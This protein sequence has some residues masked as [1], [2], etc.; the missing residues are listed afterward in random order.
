MFWNAQYSFWQDV[1][2]SNTVFWSWDC[3]YWRSWDSKPPLLSFC[4]GGETATSTAPL[5]LNVFRYWKNT[6]PGRK[7]LISTLAI[8]ETSSRVEKHSSP[9]TCWDLDFYSLRFPDISREGEEKLLQSS[10]IKQQKLRFSSLA[11]INM[12]HHSKIFSPN[13]AEVA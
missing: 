11:F 6:F 7:H 10:K 12:K 1:C 2:W 4:L 8:Q 5:F 13:T 3:L 9:G